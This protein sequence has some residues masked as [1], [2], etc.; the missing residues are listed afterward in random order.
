MRD[1]IGGISPMLSRCRCHRRVHGRGGPGLTLES[2]SWPRSALKVSRKPCIFMGANCSKTFA[3]GRG[4]LPGIGRSCPSA[5][6]HSA[7][8]NACDA[9]MPR[10]VH[11]CAMRGI[12]RLGGRQASSGLCGRRPRG[13]AALESSACRPGRKSMI[14]NNATGHLTLLQRRKRRIDVLQPVRPADQ[15]IELQ[16][17]GPVEIDQLRHASPHVR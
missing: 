7:P 13:I 1:G 17:L 15:L 8:R 3:T 2:V 12:P 6:R 10:N 16:L 9:S 4:R 11:G 5:R 14:R